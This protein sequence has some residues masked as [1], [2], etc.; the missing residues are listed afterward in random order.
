MTIVYLA[1][2]AGKF[3][4]I[5]AGFSKKVGTFYLPRGE[6]PIPHDLA[7]M[8]FPWIEEWVARVEARARGKTWKEGGLVRD[9]GAAAKF[10]NLMQY[11]RVVLL[12]DLA[13][14]QPGKLYKPLPSLPFY[15]LL[16]IIANFYSRLSYTSTL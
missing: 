16:S 6:V 8:V 7:R 14:L 5:I 4:Q 12:Q 9:D 13:V 1:Q 10:L 2:L 15:L 3:I 11:L